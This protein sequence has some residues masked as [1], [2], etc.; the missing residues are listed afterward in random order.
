MKGSWRL[1]SGIL[2]QMVGDPMGC[3]GMTAGCWK[4]GRCG[5][6]RGGNLPEGQANEC[7]AW[8]CKAQTLSRSSR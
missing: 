2:E 8:A 6:T 4:Q 3:K 1:R 7:L 5:G